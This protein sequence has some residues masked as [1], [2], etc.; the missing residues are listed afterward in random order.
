MILIVR[1]LQRLLKIASQFVEVVPEAF[2]LPGFMGLLVKFA[3]E[4]LDLLAKFV[5]LFAEV[6]MK[7]LAYANLQR[8]G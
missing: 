6:V 8:I 1:A 4:G 7:L 2:F 5:A 3:V